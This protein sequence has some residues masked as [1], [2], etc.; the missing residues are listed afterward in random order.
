[1]RTAIFGAAVLVASAFATPLAA[2]DSADDELSALADAYYD[3]QL[4]QFGM[5]DEMGLRA[6]RVDQQTQQNPLLPTREIADETAARV[7]REI[8]RIIMAEQKRCIDTLK[9]HREEFDTLVEL[10]MEKKSI[11]LDEMKEIFG[12]KSFKAHPEGNN[13]RAREDADDE[14]HEE[15]EDE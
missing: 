15:D 11:G 6:Y 4:E 3:Y 9:A 1:M 8:N 5:S 2:Q 12:G 14:D 10:L 7:D 13:P